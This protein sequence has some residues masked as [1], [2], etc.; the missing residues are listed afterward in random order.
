MISEDVWL[1]R[2]FP[3]N[4]H[5]EFHEYLERSACLRTALAPHVTDLLRC[6]VSVV[7]DFGGNAPQERQWV[8]SIFEDAK[9]EHVL[10]YINVPD[11]VCKARL[12]LRNAMAPEGSQ[13]TTD[14]E[15]DDISAYFVP[16]SSD[17]GFRIQAHGIENVT[18]EN[19]PADLR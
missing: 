12:R 10:H 2:L 6:G 11:A 13:P 1:S 3:G 16:P 19:D 4:S 7:L 14:E 8:R 5:W 17:E 18:S 15:F 9:A